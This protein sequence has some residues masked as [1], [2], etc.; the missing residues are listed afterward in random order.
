MALQI[1][2]IRLIVKKENRM[3]VLDYLQGAMDDG[4]LEDYDIMR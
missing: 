1:M 2:T 3:D 4:V